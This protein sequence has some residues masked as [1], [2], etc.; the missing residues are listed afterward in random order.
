[1]YSPSDRCFL[2]LWWTKDRDRECI[3]WGWEQ[4]QGPREARH[5][6]TGAGAQRKEGP[7]QACVSTARLPCMVNHDGGSWEFINELP[8]N[9]LIWRWSTLCVALTLLRTASYICVTKSIT[10]ESEHESNCLQYRFIT[11]LSFQLASYQNSH[12]FYPLLLTLWLSYLFHQYM[13]FLR[14]PHKTQLQ[15]LTG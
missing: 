5:Q 11:K 2:E 3:E 4:H 7:R 6:L 10:N 9:L 13:L 1:M 12:A 14:P 8:T 15:V